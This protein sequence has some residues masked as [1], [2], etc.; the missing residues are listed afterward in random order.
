MKK[1]IEPLT[2]RLLLR[3][4]C[5]EDRAPF[6]ELNA[7]PRVM[8]Y[9]PG[10]QTRQESDASVDRA[11]AHIAEHGWG[12]WAL[13]RLE[14]NRFIGFVGIK[15]APEELPFSPCV[16]IGWRLGVSYWGHGYATEAARASLDVAFQVL[17]LNEV[18]SFAVVNNRPSRVVMERLGMREDP[19]TF[20]HPLLPEGSPLRRHC[21]YRLRA[22]EWRRDNKPD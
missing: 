7:D 10:I 2:E 18:V 21:L 14:D 3:Q 12:F 15:H 16:E 13:E 8:K 6:A 5:N 20:E 19:Q 22:A 17:G 1:L 11:S 9:F 4:W